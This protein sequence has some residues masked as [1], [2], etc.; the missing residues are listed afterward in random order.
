MFSGMREFVRGMM[1]LPRRVQLWLV[2]LGALNMVGPLLFLD[3]WEARVV[4]GTFVLA[5]V[6]MSVLTRVFGFTRLLGL[7]HVV[8]L[9][10][11]PY[12]ALQLDQIPVDE[13][14]G[15]WVRGVMLANT[16]SLGFDVVDVVRYARGEREP[17]VDL[18]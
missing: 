3:H 6:L 5:F 12:L 2:L 13:A 15:L 10:L 9:L 1:R 11:L 14:I 4:L 18:G 7:G 17:L 8:W 16:V